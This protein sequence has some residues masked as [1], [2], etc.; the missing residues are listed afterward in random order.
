[1]KEIAMNSKKSLHMSN[2]EFRKY[3]HAVIDWIADYYDNVE[4][5]SVKSQA[6]PGD[7]R[8]SL[9]KTPPDSGEPMDNILEDIDSLIVDDLDI[10]DLAES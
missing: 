4:K 2:T 9:E 1:M 7:I 6:K 10:I 3:G 8:A 5:Y